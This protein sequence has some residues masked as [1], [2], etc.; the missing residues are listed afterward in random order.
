MADEELVLAEA[1]CGQAS[2]HLAQ[3]KAE[4]KKAHAVYRS[5]LTVEAETKPMSAKKTNPDE[6][7]LFCYGVYLRA[8]SGDQ[9]LAETIP[10]EVS[11]IGRVRAL[12]AIAQEP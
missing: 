10:S 7:D 11:S 9:Y 12:Y 4:E 6:L 3:C 8:V 2:R 1:R 5:L